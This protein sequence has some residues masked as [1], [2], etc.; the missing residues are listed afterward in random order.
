MQ[1]RQWRNQTWNT[2]P[3]TNAKTVDAFLF[4]EDFVHTIFGFVKRAF[5]PEHFYITDRGSCDT[6]PAP[7]LADP[8]DRRTSVVEPI[9][10]PGDPPQVGIGAIGMSGDPDFRAWAARLAIKAGDEPDPEEFQRLMSIADYWKRLADL[11]DWERDGFRPAS[12]AKSPQ[13]LS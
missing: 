5:E 9:G 1:E 13:R 11:D 3:T 4:R 10:P 6:M 7:N 12:E 2:P 8:A